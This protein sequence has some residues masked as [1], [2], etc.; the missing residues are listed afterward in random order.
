[1]GV[2]WQRPPFA[3]Q[4]RTHGRPDCALPGAPR[5]HRSLRAHV[6]QPAARGCRVQ[7]S[8]PGALPHRRVVC[9]LHPRSVHDAAGAPAGEHRKAARGA[10]GDVLELGAAI[11]RSPEQADIGSRPHTSVRAVADR[12]HQ[13]ARV[14]LLPRR[15]SCR[16][17]SAADFTEQDNGTAPKV[18][19]V[20]QAFVRIY[21]DGEN[22]VGEAHRHPRLRRPRRGHR[23]RRGCQVHGAARRRASYRLSAVAAAGG[24]RCELRRSARRSEP[25]RSF[26][27]LRYSCRRCARSIRRYPC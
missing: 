9:R 14:E 15:W 6:E 24:R 26:F 13:R 2:P 25:D 11:A 7:P 10:R 4:P 20:N 3:S 22:P 18:A 16:W 5:Q 8:R 17:S 19:V 27:L 23:R 12:Q 21:F 1:M